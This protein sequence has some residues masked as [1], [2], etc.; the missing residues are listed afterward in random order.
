VWRR[1]ATLRTN[2]YGIFSG[3][4]GLAGSAPKPPAKPPGR[5][6]YR[7]L[8]LADRPTAYWRLGE[9]KGNRSARDE[10]G[11]LTGSYVGNPRLGAPGAIV[12]DRNTAMVLDGKND[13]V[14]F[15]PVHSP[16][17][18]EAWI[19]T[20]A[21]RL[22]AVFSNR[23]PFSHFS[24]LGVEPGGYTL[25]YDSG[26][27]Y[28]SRW[29]SDGT[30]HHIVSTYDNGVVRVY[31]DGELDEQASILRLEGSAPARIGFDPAPPNRFRGSV[32][33]VAIYDHALSARRIKAHYA[34]SGRRPATLEQFQLGGK[35][36]FLRARLANGSAASLP[37]SLA[38]VPDR[39]VRPFGGVA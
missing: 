23:N 22:G 36:P 26:P 18:V 34:A 19:K 3:R 6:D 10:R 37:F 20:S 12:G 29:I 9:P 16:A 31:V 4:V 7:D 39:F 13:V 11:V 30:W 32:D 21:N 2:P 38:K 35:G 25:A 17:T 8:V 24:F 14:E 1:L 28:G 27:V 33:E 15:G 5:T